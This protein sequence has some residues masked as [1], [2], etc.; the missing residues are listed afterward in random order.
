MQILEDMHTAFKSNTL[1]KVQNKWVIYIT[2]HKKQP[3]SEELVL[4]QI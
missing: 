1:S 3:H 4:Q 2:N